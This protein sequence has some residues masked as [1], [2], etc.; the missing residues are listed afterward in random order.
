MEKIELSNSLH[1]LEITKITMGDNGMGNPVRKKHAEAMFEKYLDMGG[2]CIDTARMYNAG[3]SEVNLAPFLKANRDRLV[4]VTKC[5]HHNVITK[6]K[7]VTPLAITNDVHRS[8]RALKTDCLDVLLLHRDDASKPVSRIMPTLDRLVK[9]GKVK[10]IGASNWSVGR[11]AEANDFAK[12]N[13]L[14]PFSVSQIN[15]SLAHSTPSVSRDVTHVMMNDVE[16]G[17]YQDEKM[18][19]MAWS[20]Q[21]KG[22]FTQY[23]NGNVKKGPQQRYGWSNENKRRATRLQQLSEELNVPIGTLVIS[24]L[25]SQPISVVPVCGASN[26]AQF[27]EVMLADSIKLTPAQLAFLEKGSN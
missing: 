21:A 22:F 8:L 25:T 19:V 4:V 26:M 1:K 7:R 17:W 24:Y 14:T 15:Y 23:L 10:I 2:N 5:A 20:P 11:L 13:G 18:P 16:Y 9:D 12:E 3:R 27:E 6:H